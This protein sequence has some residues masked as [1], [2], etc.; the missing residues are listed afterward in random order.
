MSHNLGNTQRWRHVSSQS[1]H[2]ESQSQGA[3][4]AHKAA[5]VT[6][7]SIRKTSHELWRSIMPAA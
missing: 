1:A 3:T 2:T 6:C 7:S 5:H 4:A